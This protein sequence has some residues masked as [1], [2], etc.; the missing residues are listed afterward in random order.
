MSEIDFQSLLD[1]YDKSDMARFTRNFVDD[2]EAAMS[3]EIEIEADMDWSGVVCLGMGGSGAGG[4]FLSALA[5]DS[6]GLPFVVW[7]NYGL[8]SWWGPDWL[9]LATSYSGNTEETLDGVREVISAGGTVVGI[10]SGGELDDVI[11][12]SEGSACLNVPPG[13]MPRSAFGHLFGTQLS[14]CWALGILPK[15]NNNEIEEMLNR[16]SK[17]SLESDLATNSGMAATLSKSIV[18]K[19]IG[20]VAPTC[21]GAAAYRFTCQLNENSAKFAIATDIPEMNHNEIVAW[22]SK[23]AHERALLFLS[24]KDLHPRTNSRIEWM[25]EEIEAKPTWVIDC[26]GESLLERLLYAAHVTDWVSIGLALLT[27][28]D[29]SDMPAIESLKSHLASVQ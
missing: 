24:S 21:L 17:V 5:D 8:P 23:S 27:D 18:G 15:P 9:V 28:E 12:Q 13:Q 19:E 20:I 26:E 11:S 14:A 7:N 6:G 29:P 2:L 4:M 25:L 16:L 1:K 10:C 22:T 3:A